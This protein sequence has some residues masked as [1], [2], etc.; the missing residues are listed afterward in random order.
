MLQ[1]RVIPCLLI[2]NSGLVKTIQFKNPTY[3]GDP[4]NAVRIFNEKQVDELVLL[5]IAASKTDREPDYELI[6][7]I[8]SE[9]FMPIAF[10]GGVRTLA[11]AKRLINLGVEKIVINTAVLNNTLLV[12]QIADSLGSQ[13]VVICLDIKKDWLG[14]YQLFNSSK[15]KAVNLDLMKYLH[16]TVNAGAGEIFLNSVDC[17]GIG[18]GYDLELI[19]RISSAIDVPVI[20]CGGAGS[21]NHFKNAVDAGASAVAAGSM[22]V[23]MGKRRAV[24]INYP[25]R[26]QLEGVLHNA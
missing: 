25:S 24:M 26:E 18:S 11:Q 4:I 9:A 1:T 6:E 5:D 16:S 2:Q 20:A 10:G 15:G 12:R 23:F 21:V 8:V 17:D 7:N 22:F 3:V 19:E 14:K 13:S